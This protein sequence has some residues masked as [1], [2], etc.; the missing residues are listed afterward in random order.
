MH[1]TIRNSRPSVLHIPDAALRLEPGQTVGVT[2]LSPQMEMLVGAGALE[3]VVSQATPPTAPEPLP[4][5]KPAREGKRGGRTSTAPTLP[6]VTETDD[7][8]Q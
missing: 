2:A 6:V 3:V 5:A 4:A 8:A 1:Y 7:D